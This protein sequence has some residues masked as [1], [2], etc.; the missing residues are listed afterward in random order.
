MCKGNIIGWRDVVTDGVFFLGCR[1]YMYMCV[2]YATTPFIVFRSISGG[3]RAEYSKFYGGN[4]DTGG[5]EERERE[6]AEAEYI[7]QTVKLWTINDQIRTYIYRSKVFV[8]R[9]KTDASSK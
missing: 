8:M 7:V 3:E 2:G 4:A 6:K 5:W 9:I 1:G